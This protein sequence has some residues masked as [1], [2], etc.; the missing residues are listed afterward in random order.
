MKT[1]SKLMI[2]VILGIFILPGCEKEITV[3]D[4]PVSLTAKNGSVFIP[5]DTVSKSFD[6]Y[7]P[8]IITQGHLTGVFSDTIRSSFQLAIVSPAHWDTLYHPC[9]TVVFPTVFSGHT[10]VIVTDVNLT[11]FTS[12]YHFAILGLTSR[13]MTEG[14]FGRPTIHITVEGAG[15]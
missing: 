13:E 12:P 6:A 2:F 8:V 11:N 9:D 10:R 3:L 5:I 15:Y 4:V 1:F 14:S 7:S